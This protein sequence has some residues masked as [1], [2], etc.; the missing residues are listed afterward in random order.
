MKNLCTELLRDLTERSIFFS[1]K[2]T[3]GR[4]PFSPF[5]CHFMSHASLLLPPFSLS[6]FL[7]LNLSSSISFL[8]GSLIYTLFDD[9]T[10]VLQLVYL[11]II[12]TIELSQK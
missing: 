8:P 9:A 12:I 4:S 7:S 10:S 2:I 11:S 6:H 5:V 3:D 1:G